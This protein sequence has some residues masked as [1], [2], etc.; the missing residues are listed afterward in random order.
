[1]MNIAVPNYFLETKD[2]T[3]LEVNA[4]LYIKH[5]KNYSHKISVRNTMH[6]VLLVRSG[7]KTI[8]TN[9]DIFELYAYQ[10]GFFSQ[11]H[12]FLSEN[13]PEYHAIAIYFDDHFVLNFVKKYRLDL[14]EISK[15]IVVISYKQNVVLETLIDLM[16]KDI[17]KPNI[18]QKELLELKI[19]MLFLELLQLDPL[20]MKVFFQHILSTSSERMRYILEE[21]LD[22]IEKVEDMY[23]LMRMSSAHFHKTFLEIFKTSPK[24]WLDVQRMKKATFLLCN[25]QKSILNIATECGY[26]TASWFIVQFKKYY[27]ITPKQYRVKNQH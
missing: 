5:T 7:S 19:E 6:G 27:N 12:Y 15:N 9:E 1:M 20:K 25:T 8:Q 4:Q 23:R 17:S 2:S 10:A 18:Y 21:N 14:S 26:S 3:L 11:G 16:D 13:D 24:S 22:M